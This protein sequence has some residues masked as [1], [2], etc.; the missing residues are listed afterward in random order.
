MK[1]LLGTLALA[2]LAV[3]CLNQREYM[4][5]AQNLGP[6]GSVST[7]KSGSVLLRGPSAS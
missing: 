4:D 1:L 3:G 5:P 2:T 7:L 6:N